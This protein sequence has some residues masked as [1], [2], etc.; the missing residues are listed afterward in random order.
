MG[1]LKK[2]EIKMGGMKKWGEERRSRI[3]VLI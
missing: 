2:K 1:Q 3:V